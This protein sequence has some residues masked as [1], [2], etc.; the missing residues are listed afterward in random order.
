M[1]TELRC[2]HLLLIG[3]G[4]G[5]FVCLTIQ[6]FFMVL[7]LSTVIIKLVSDGLVHFLTPGLF[8]AKDVVCGP[9][10]RTSGTLGLRASPSSPGLCS[11]GNESK[12]PHHS[13]FIPDPIHLTDIR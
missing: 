10:E 13:W 9:H 1:E 6:T 3:K 5:V 4:W 11:Y 7:F 2:A 12:A 8:Q